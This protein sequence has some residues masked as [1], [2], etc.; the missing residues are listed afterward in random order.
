MNEIEALHTAARSYC[1]DRDAEIEIY[2]VRLLKS[3][4]LGPVFVTD[5]VESI[6]LGAIQLAVEGVVPND[7]SS[8]ADLR[9]FLLTTARTVDAYPIRPQRLTPEEARSRQNAAREAFRQ[10]IEGLSADALPAVEPLPYRRVLSL[11]ECD[12]LWIRLKRRWDAPKPTAFWYPLIEGP[13]PPYTQ[14]FHERPFNAAIPPQRLQ[15][16]LAHHRIRR[17][18]RL[19]TGGHQHFEMDVSLLFPWGIGGEPYWTSEKMDWLLYLSHENSLTVAGEWFLN[20]V[21]AAWPTCEQYLYPP[22]PH[23]LVRK[24]RRVLDVDDIE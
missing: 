17:V 12:R 24:G 11:R 10:F 19:H 23:Y 6:V 18:Y 16:I 22:N 8:V 5:A 4:R 13:P 20:A 3:G 21:K 2:D 9:A 1:I 7:F 14:A 15:A